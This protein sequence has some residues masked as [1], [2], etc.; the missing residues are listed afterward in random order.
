LITLID[1][2]VFLNV[3]REEEQ[4]LEAS[5]ELLR[6][7]QSREIIGLS[8]CMVLM[9]IK[10]ALFEKKEY[11]KADKAVSLIEE[12]VQIAPVDKEIAKEAI[13]LKIRKKT[14]LLDSIHVV[15]AVMNSAVFVTRD[16]DLRRKIED[17]VTVKTPEEVLKSATK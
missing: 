11:A 10:W 5:E 4:F 2:N 13:D 8:S 15:T 6:K 3:I 14:E 17:I 16:N 12:I 1:T 9:E 7:A